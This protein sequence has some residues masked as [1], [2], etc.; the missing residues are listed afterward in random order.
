MNERNRV[1]LILVSIGLGEPFQFQHLGGSEPGRVR[2]V[3]PVLLFT[4][5]LGDT[6][7]GV[8]TLNPIYLLGWCLPRRAARTFRL[9]CMQVDSLKSDSMSTPISM[10]DDAIH[11]PPSTP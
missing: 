1:A 6:A 2:R 11:K 3:L 5:S 9:D 4:T 10:T 7:C 8:G